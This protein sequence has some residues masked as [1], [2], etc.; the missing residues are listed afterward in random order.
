MTPITVK[1]STNADVVFS[2]IRQ[3]AGNVSG[4]LQ[5]AVT[6]AGMNRTA[7][8]KIEISAT[9]SQ[10]KSTPVV[11]VSVP[12]GAVVDG[13]YKKQ[14]QVT[15][16]ATATLPPDSPELARANAEAFARN[17]LANAQVQALFLNGVAP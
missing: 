9:Q 2:V 15:R 14:G 17:V 1:D 16:V 12:Y 6:G 4:I 8:A 3:P 10:G 7:F 13:N 11:T 5:A